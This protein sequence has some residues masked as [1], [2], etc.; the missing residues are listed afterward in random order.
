MYSRLDKKGI[1]KRIQINKDSNPKELII[2]HSSATIWMWLGNVP[3]KTFDN[4]HFCESSHSLNLVGSAFCLKPPP[5]YWAAVCS[6]LRSHQQPLDPTQ[7]EPICYSNHISVR[8]WLP[9]RC[10]CLLS[11]NQIQN[12]IPNKDSRWYSGKTLS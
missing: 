5:K 4:F 3:P 7:S 6:Q 8:A 9:G 11:W 12:K 2:A 1:K 10:A